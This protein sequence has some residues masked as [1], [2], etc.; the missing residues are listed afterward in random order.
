V[1][2]GFISAIDSFYK[3][4][5]TLLLLR[6]LMRLGLLGLAQKSGPLKNKVMK[7]AMGL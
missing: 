2:D 1:C 4:R 5:V 6:R 7:Y 3:V